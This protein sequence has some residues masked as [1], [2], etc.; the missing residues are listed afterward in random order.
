MITRNSIASTAAAPRRGRWLNVVFV[1][2]APVSAARL[3]AH[4]LVCSRSCFRLV[5]AW[6][7][8]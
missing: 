2:R 8:S 4:A 7:G 5:P 3:G 1:M 6:L